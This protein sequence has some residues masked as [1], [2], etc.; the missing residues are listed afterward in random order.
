MTGR[1][2]WTKSSYS[3]S[4]GGNCV[5]LARTPRTIHIRDSKT[6]A[7]PHLHLSPTTWATFLDSAADRRTR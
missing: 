2:K 6:P 4:D 7:A 1:M 5:E 3:D